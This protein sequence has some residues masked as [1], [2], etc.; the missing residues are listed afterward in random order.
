MNKLFELL[1]LDKKVFPD[2]TST[3]FDEVLASAKVILNRGD[4]T[5][6]AVSLHNT[7]QQVY[8]VID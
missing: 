6:L 1:R 4:I 5:S 7:C 3:I 8:V 2:A